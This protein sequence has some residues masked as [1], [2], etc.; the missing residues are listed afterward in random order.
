[1]TD[2]SS[3][4]EQIEKIIISQNEVIINMAK[5][6]NNDDLNVLTE[7]YQSECN[8]FKELH[9]NIPDEMSKTID[10]IRQ[11][12]HLLQEEISRISPQ[13]LEEKITTLHKE[14]QQSASKQFDEFIHY[15]DSTM[16]FTR[17]TLQTNYDD[18]NKLK[19]EMTTL[20]ESNS[21]DNNA[22]LELDDQIKLLKN[23]I[24]N[25]KHQN[26]INASNFRCIKHEMRIVK[27]QFE[28]NVETASR[29]DRLAEKIK[30][31]KV[32]FRKEFVPGSPTKMPETDRIETLQQDLELLKHNFI[33]S[34]NDHTISLNS[35]LGQLKLI[36][37]NL[38]ALHSNV[39]SRLNDIEKRLEIQP[40]SIDE[41]N[42]PLNFN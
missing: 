27:V 18:I 4:L 40:T 36:R 38:E 32:D 13:Q 10:Q 26:E 33:D 2:F 11:D 21:K 28:D 20:T 41:F 14:Y 15:Y 22:L 19:I 16:K 8:K 1:M 25:L 5:L 23:E 6:H 37:K 12:V 34:T 24:D 35:Q 31:M 7:Q 42:L 3:Y 30:K 29:V 39:Q 17:E 9:T